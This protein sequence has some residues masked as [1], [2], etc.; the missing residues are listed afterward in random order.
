MNNFCH[1]NIHKRNYP[2][3]IAVSRFN[4]LEGVDPEKIFHRIIAPGP[5]PLGYSYQAKKLSEDTHQLPPPAGPEAPD[6]TE[7]VV[8]NLVEFLLVALPLP[9]PVPYHIAVGFRKSNQI[10][11]TVYR[12]CLREKE[13]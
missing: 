10:Y 5:L 11:T 4:L 1:S 8:N 12:Q 13:I 7:E 2:A 3:E 9:P 6:N